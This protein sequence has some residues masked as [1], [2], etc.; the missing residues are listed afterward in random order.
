MKRFYKRVE[1]G[2]VDDGFTVF[3]DGRPIKTPAKE[4]LILP[5]SDLAD[6]IASEWDAQAEK[7]DP[8]SMPSMRY[9]ATAIDRVTPQRDKVISEIS[10][11]GE[12]DLLCYRATYPEQLVDRQ[13]K[14]WDPWLE[15]LANTHG[16]RL[17]VTS[18]V[19]YVQQ[20]PSALK[21]MSDI[22]A[23]QTDLHLAALHDVVSLTGSLVLTL[24]AL[25]QKLDADQ[26]FDISELDETHVIEQWGED[27]EQTKRRKNNK[28]SLTAAIRFLELCD[29]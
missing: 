10:G 20:Y 22:V 13:S 12:T 18:G 8:F 24:A 1:T 29:R 4:K 26:A 16:V 28:L 7:V 25:D 9:A 14:A 15:W 3:L 17:N 11:F 27:A 23:S 19:G 5:N 21:K 2:P 6:E